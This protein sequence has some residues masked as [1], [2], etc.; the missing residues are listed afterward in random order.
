MAERRKSSFEDH[1]SVAGSSTKTASF[2][3]FNDQELLQK[4]AEELALTPTDGAIVDTGSV[5]GTAGAVVS[6]TESLVNPQLAVAGTDLA[7]V[8]AGEV[9][10]GGAG[11]DLAIGDANGYVTDA[12][13]FG[14]TEAAVAAAAEGVAPEAVVEAE[15]VGQLIAHS[16][17][18]ELQKIANY[19]AYTESLDLLKT[20]GL[21]DSYNIQDDGMSK[22]ASFEV[23]GLE[24]I[25]NNQA[26][27]HGDIIS[28]ANEYI[29]FTKMAEDAEAEG[30]EEAQEDAAAVIE[31]AKEEAASDVATEVEKEE[32]IDEA[33]AAAKEEAVEEE[34]VSHLLDNSDVVNAVRTLQY[35]NVM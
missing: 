9:P 29:E 13:S 4:L 7:A 15:K 30:R 31:E 16:F 17:H 23:G 32:A 10:A 12:D 11:S 14:R 3:R 26:L 24:K 6:A 19:Q 20:A 34:K 35:Y 21:L 33:V 8:A 25:A 18:A 1:I 2:K 22:T 28:A 27:S 5:Q